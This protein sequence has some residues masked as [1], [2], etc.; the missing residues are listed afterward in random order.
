MFKCILSIT[1]ESC[2]E[3]ARLTTFVPAPQASG[4]QPHHLNFNPHPKRPLP[5]QYVKKEVYMQIVKLTPLSRSSGPHRASS[6]IG[7]SFSHKDDTSDI[8]LNI[9]QRLWRSRLLGTENR[10]SDAGRRGIYHI[11]SPWSLVLDQGS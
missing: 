7:I 11:N 2:T 3:I 5:M 9:D 4:G 10:K 6:S 8:L 1:M